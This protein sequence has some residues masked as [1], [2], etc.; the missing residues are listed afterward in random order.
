MSVKNIYVEF[1]NLKDLEGTLPPEEY[2]RRLK[3]LKGKL[4]GS[5][6]PVFDCEE[7]ENFSLKRILRIT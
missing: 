3:L 1:Q 6:K 2:L 4:N 5:A 7:S